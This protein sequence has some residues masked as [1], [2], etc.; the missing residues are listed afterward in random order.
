MSTDDHPRRFCLLS[1][2]IENYSGFDNDRQ[3]TAQKQLRDILDRAARQ[4][5]VARERW[6]TQANGD[7]ELALVPGDVS[8][9]ALVSDFVRELDDEL[10][11]YNRDRVRE[12]RLRLRLAVHHGLAVIG[13]NG[14]PGVDV[15]HVARL[16]DADEVRTALRD[17]RHANLVVVV[18]DR[19]Y[20]DI[21]VQRYR[22]LRPEEFTRIIVDRPAKGFTAVAWVRVPGRVIGV[23]W[24]ATGHGRE[25]K[26]VCVPD[27]E[28]AYAGV[29]ELAELPDHLLAEIANFFDVYRMLD[30]D[31]FTSCDGYEGAAAAAEVLRAA[32][33]PA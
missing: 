26:L 25:A 8:E 17:D 10:S 33:T 18:S 24:I 3:V 14:F 23:F 22:G 4:A 9:A 27:G 7:G 19:L 1:T 16:V 11:R 12:A 32:R 28:P 2:D 13:E 30:P 20:G 29:S 6:T 21:V 31:S 15:V 5:G